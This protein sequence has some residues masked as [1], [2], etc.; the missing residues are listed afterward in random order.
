MVVNPTHNLGLILFSVNK[1]FRPFEVLIPYSLRCSV[2]IE[3]F[4]N[5]LVYLHN[6]KLTSDMRI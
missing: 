6:N 2:F 3:G 1:S 4:P 5:T